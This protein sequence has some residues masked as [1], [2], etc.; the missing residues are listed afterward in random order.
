M[1]NLVKPAK[2]PTASMRRSA[3]KPYVPVQPKPFNEYEPRSERAIV[4]PWLAVDEPWDELRHSL[5]SVQRFFKDK[6]CPIYVIGSGRPKWLKDGG[7]VEYIHIPEY[8]K[9]RQEGLW[10]AWQIGMQI[11]NEVCWTND[12]IYFLKPTGWED[13]RVALTEGTL[14]E[15]EDQMR[16]DTN[17]WRVALG[18]ACAELRRRGIDP[19]W[20]FATHTPY[21]FEREKSLEIL[22][23][24]YIAYK[25]GW[26]T[27]YHNHHQTPHED[28]GPHKTNNLPCPG[29]PRYLNHKSGGPDART[30]DELRRLFGTPAPWEA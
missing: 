28:C 7:R 16:A 24:Y 17:G 21:L 4:C 5:R 12:D 3:P 2:Y 8:A 11:A 20:R 1:A 22:R 15:H 30:Q 25:G 6:D 14:N 18:E 23:E 9:S 10:A 13:M 26:V 19:V 27:L 29:S